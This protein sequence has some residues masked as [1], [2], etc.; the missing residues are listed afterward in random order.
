MGGTGTS[1]PEGN[2]GGTGTS[3]PGGN[4]GGT[5]ISELLVGG[6]DIPESN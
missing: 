1:R 2:G 4:G 3:R 5:G 6:E